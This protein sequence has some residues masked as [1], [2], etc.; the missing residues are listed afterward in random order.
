MLY[1]VALILH[2]VGHALTGIVVGRP[3]L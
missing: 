1:P 3:P 2:E